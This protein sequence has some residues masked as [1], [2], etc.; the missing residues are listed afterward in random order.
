MIG[1]LQERTGNRRCKCGGVFAALRM[2]DVLWV[3][4]EVTP[5]RCKDKGKSRSFDCVAHES[6]VSHFAQDDKVLDWEE[7]SVGEMDG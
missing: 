5:S 7:G 2:T 1:G 4:K 6:A 3:C